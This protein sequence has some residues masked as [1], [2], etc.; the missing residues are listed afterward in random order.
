[1]IK[2]Y[3]VWVYNEE[4]GTKE[5]KEVVNTVVN[6]SDHTIKLFTEEE[7]I[8]TTEEPPFYIDNQGKRT[9]I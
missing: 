4:T 8:E 7:F 6:E 2:D 5:L 9:E 1:M 3:K